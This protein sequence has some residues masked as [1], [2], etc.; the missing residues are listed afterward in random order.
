MAKKPNKA[1]PSLPEPCCDSECCDSSCSCRGVNSLDCCR[2]EAVVSVDSRGQMM[3][4]K[5]LRERAGFMPDQKRA[6]VSWK[7]GDALCC[8]TL[9]RADDLAEMVRRTYGPLLSTAIRES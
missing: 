8:V 4:P 1:K 6:L 7:K 9:Q 5:E 2:V 3:L